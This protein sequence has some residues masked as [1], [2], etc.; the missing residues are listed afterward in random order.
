MPLRHLL[1]GFALAAGALVACQPATA[2]PATPTCSLS[3]LILSGPSTVEV[4][5]SIVLSYTPTQTAGSSCGSAQLVGTWSSSA[6]TIASVVAGPIGFAAQVNGE[7]PGPAVIAV[8]LLSRTATRS[9]TVTPAPVASILVTP[10]NPTV[11]AGQTQ[12]MAAACLAGNGQP[13]TP[14]APAWSMPANAAATITPGGLVTA[15][16]PGTATAVATSGSVSGQTTITV[17]AAPAQ[18]RL[19]YGLVFASGTPDPAYGFNSLGGDLTAVRQSAG[20]YQVTIPGFGGAAGESRLPF[21]F[22]VSSQS[23]VCVAVTWA[24]IGVTQATVDV[25][26]TT[27]GVVH[28]DSDFVVLAVGQGGLPGNFAFG[29]SGPVAG[30]PPVGT[31]ATLGAASAWSSAGAVQFRRDDI[32][33]NGRYALITGLPVGPP[34]A[35]AVVQAPAGDAS[36]RCT[37]GSWASALDVVCYPPGSGSFGNA[38]FTGLLLEQGRPGMRIGSA[39]ANQPAAATYTAPVLAR[40]NSSGGAI[41]IT[42]SSTGTYQVVFQGLGRADASRREVVLVSTQALFSPGTCRVSAP[43][44]AAVAADLSVNVRCVDGAGVASDQSFFIVVLE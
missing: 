36:S 2:P 37:L 20:R 15:V 42:R 41:T 16:A 24:M 19:A 27:P 26:C 21:V 22:A 11:L 28:V 31:T 9:I 10:A 25:E 17:A 30:M 35:F 32:T 39:W 3:T 38:P 4:G 33:P 18:A 23:T 14:C 5:Q 13:T 8:N 43:W 12:Q 1:V 40:R 7:S 34:V 6:P 44:S 29:F